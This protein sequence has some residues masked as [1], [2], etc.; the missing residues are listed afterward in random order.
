M[1][2]L[3]QKDVYYIK[4]DKGNSLIIIDKLDYDDRMLDHISSGNYSKIKVNPL[5]KMVNNARK[6]IQNIVQIFGDDG[7]NKNLKWK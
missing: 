6:V 3:Q 4:A 5:R 2:S 7:I 1:E